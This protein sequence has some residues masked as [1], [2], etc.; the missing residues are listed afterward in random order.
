M[1]PSSGLLMSVACRERIG[2]A[3]HSP[4]LAMLTLAYFAVRCTPAVVAKGFGEAHLQNPKV[5]SDMT[6][7]HHIHEA[8]ILH[9]LGERSKLKDQRPYTFMVS[10]PSYRREWI[11]TDRNFGSR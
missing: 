6:A 8:G 5:V 1:L 4:G 3:H 2:D 11:W 7:L 10:F 9:N